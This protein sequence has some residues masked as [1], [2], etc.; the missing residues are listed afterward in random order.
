MGTDH[1]P[2]FPSI[3]A[4]LG[5]D[6]MAHRQ[7]NIDR[8]LAGINEHPDRQSNYRF[9]ESA[10]EVMAL[11]AYALGYE[12]GD[13]VRMFRDALEPRLR[14]LQLRGTTQYTRITPARTPGEQPVTTVLTD[15]GSGCS[16]YGYESACRAHMLGLPGVAAEIAPLIWDPPDATYVGR[17]S[18]ICTPEQQKLAYA[19]RD[20]G[21]PAYAESRPHLKRIA[22]AW[23][24]RGFPKEIAYQAGLL[25]AIG[26]GNGAEF[27]N[28]LDQLL[29]WHSRMANREDNRF[30]RHRFLCLPA[31]GLGAIALARQTIRIEDWPQ[32][33]IYLPLELIRHAGGAA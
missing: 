23:R 21:I 5:A 26:D 3:T 1:Q 2:R 11:E 13:V 8:A 20:L 24:V 12:I 15:F 32:D 10:Y 16:W 18:E 28:Q 30:D 9:L 22:L 25:Q 31:L 33:D 19:L 14:V 17:R 6:I 27:T 7:Q 29:A 4:T